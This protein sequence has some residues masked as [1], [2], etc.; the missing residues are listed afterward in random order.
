MKEKLNL[1]QKFRKFFFSLPKGEQQAL[2]DIMT[3][4]RSEDD[5]STR[6]K[7]FTTSRIRGALMGKSTTQFVGR[8][9]LFT[10]PKAAEAYCKL[11][12][13]LDDFPRD[14]KTTYRRSNYHFKDH[15]RL[16]VD[17]L[18]KYGFKGKITDLKKRKSFTD[19]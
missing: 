19:E 1:V 14:L 12:G 8:A 9:I 4:L 2:W 3:A 10:N 15:F 16:A 11:Y 5:G 18:L 7:M 17:A 6:L 13:W